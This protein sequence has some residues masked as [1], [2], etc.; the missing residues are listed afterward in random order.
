MLSLKDSKE[1]AT[2]NHLWGKEVVKIGEKKE[3][4][5]LYFLLFLLFGFSTGT[6]MTGRIKQH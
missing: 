3:E 1:T 4:K 5:Y 6:C 2:S